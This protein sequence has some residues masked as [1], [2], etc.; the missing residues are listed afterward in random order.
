MNEITPDIITQCQNDLQKQGYCILP[1]GLPEG[2]Q[3]SLSNENYQELDFKM[4]ALLAP[5]KGLFNILAHFCELKEIEHIIS[6]RDSE[7]EW[8]EDGIWHDDGSRELAFSL[9]L[10]RD[11]IEGGVLEIRS[12][13]QSIHHHLQTPDYGHMIIFKTG[14]ENFEHKIN[15]V[16]KGRRTIIAGW[17]YSSLNT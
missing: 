14:K 1:I 2:I 8:E 5:N 7:N 6:I 11:S 13:D 4:S 17:C 9:S 10:T 16:S 15:K 3:K 12:K